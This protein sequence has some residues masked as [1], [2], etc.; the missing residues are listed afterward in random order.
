QRAPVLALEV[1]GV[2]ILVLLRRV[3][4][5]LDRAIGPMAEPLRVFAHPRVIRRTLPGEIERD[6]HVEAARPAGERVE[7][8]ERPERGLDRGVPA[9]RRADR[10]RAAGIAGAGLKRVVASFAEARADRVNRRQ[11]DHVET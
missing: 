3:L 6:L 11:I 4:R 10:P 8:L 2:D 5:V 9:G 7:V 1:E